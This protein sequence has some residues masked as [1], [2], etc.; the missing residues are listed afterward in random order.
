MRSLTR[1]GR[2]AAAGAVTV[3]A[4]VVSL[5]AAGPATAATTGFPAADY[6]VPGARDAVFVQTDNTTGNQVVAYRRA[7]AGALTLA[8]TYPT[9]GLGGQLAGSVVDH[10][11]SQ[12][13]LTYDPAHA[14]L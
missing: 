14:L 1:L 10:L 2:A 11:A 6:G 5:A 7:A 4:A 13:S 3:S 8:A 9:G 12:G